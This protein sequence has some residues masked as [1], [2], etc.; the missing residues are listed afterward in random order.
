MVK[1]VDIRNQVHFSK[2]ADLPH[3]WCSEY[4]NLHDTCNNLL[5]VTE[6]CATLLILLR[7]QQVDIQNCETGQNEQ[8]AEVWQNLEKNCD[9]DE[10]DYGVHQ[11][12]EIS[13]CYAEDEY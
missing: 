2:I 10:E 4:R 11:D 1:G 13:P 8:R 6:T 9:R 3:D 12:D 7:P 5:N